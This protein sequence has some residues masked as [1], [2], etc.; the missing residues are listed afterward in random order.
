MV[1][2][3]MTSQVLQCSK[4]IVDQTQTAHGVGPSQDE[5]ISH[6]VTSASGLMCTQR[7]K[8]YKTKL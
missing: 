6:V 5:R 2:S 7:D 4:R 1:Q 8:P 3:D